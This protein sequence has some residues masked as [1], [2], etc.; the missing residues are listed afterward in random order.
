VNSTKCEIHTNWSQCVPKKS[1]ETGRC[2]L[3]KYCSNLGEDNKFCKQLKDCQDFEPCLFSNDLKPTPPQI[4]TSTPTFI[5]TST[6]SFISTSTPTLIGASIPSSIPASTP[7]SITTS[8]PSSIP[9]STP[10]SIPTS[11]PTSIPT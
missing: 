9:T 1:V 3:S 11:T 7:T 5:P 6:P 8:T 10:T 4:V 2:K